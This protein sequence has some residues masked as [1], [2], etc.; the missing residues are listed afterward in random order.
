MP[1][2]AVQ[3]FTTSIDGRRRAVSRGDLVASNDPVVKG[4]EQMFEPVVE[5]ATAAPGAKRGQKAKKATSKD[6]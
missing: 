2:R 3:S 5:D 6:T 1:V 4:R